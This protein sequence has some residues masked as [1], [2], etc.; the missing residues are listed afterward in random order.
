[1]TDRAIAF[2]LTLAAIALLVSL[3]AAGT[4]SADHGKPDGYDWANQ[5]D[6][7]SWFQDQYTRFDLI[8][9]YS[10]KGTP[11]PGD[12]EFEEMGEEADESGEMA[13]LHRMQDFDYNEPPQLARRWNY[14]QAVEKYTNHYNNAGSHGESIY[15]YYRDGDDFATLEGDD[16]YYDR[17]PY[18]AGKDLLGL[19][20]KTLLQKGHVSIFSIQ[21]S[22][23]VH[24]QPRQ[25]DSSQGYDERDLYIRK[26]GTVI[27]IGDA[28]ADELPDDYLDCGDHLIRRWKNDECEEGDRKYEWDV[29]GTGLKDVDVTITTPN[30][31]TVTVGS[32][33]EQYEDGVAVVSYQIPDDVTGEQRLEINANAYI[34]FQ[35][36]VYEQ[37]VAGTET[38]DCEADLK[39]LWDAGECLDDGTREV[40]IYEWDYSH[41]ETL[42]PDTVSVSDSQTVYIP[43]GFDDENSDNPTAQVAH[44]PHGGT[45]VKVDIS[46]KVQR[47]DKWSRLELQT[48]DP[49]RVSA[50]VPA[51][52]GETDINLNLERPVTEDTEV[53]VWARGDFGTLTKQLEITDQDG[54]VIFEGSSGE[55]D[56]RMS[57][58]HYLGARDLDELLDPTE[59]EGPQEVTLTA[60][61][62]EAVDEVNG[63]PPRVWLTVK[64]PPRELDVGVKSKWYY[65]GARHTG[66]DAMWAKVV[67]RGWYDFRSETR[68]E[69]SPIRPVWIHSYPKKNGFKSSV[70]VRERDY[71]T[72]AGSI[73]PETTTSPALDLDTWCKHDYWD[74]RKDWTDYAKWTSPVAFAAVE[75]YDYLY[76]YDYHEDQCFWNFPVANQ[77]DTDRKEYYTVEGVEYETLKSADSV[78]LHGMVQGQTVEAE[79]QQERTVELVDVEIETNLIDNEREEVAPGIYRVPAT[80]T[81]TNPHGEPISTEER[82]IAGEYIRVNN[83]RMGEDLHGNRAFYS[84]DFQTDEDG[85]VYTDVYISDDMDLEAEYN[86][87]QWWRIPED[88]QAYTDEVALQPAATADSRSLATGFWHLGVILIIPLVLFYYINKSVGIDFGIEEYRDLL[89]EVVPPGFWPVLFLG[90]LFLLVTY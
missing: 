81:V 11:D 69:E 54:N 12:E 73:N 46:D 80:I 27:A 71:K 77:T 75:I 16:E 49:T 82:D 90:L 26:Q 43:R 15:P 25:G 57:D 84:E 63:V 17:N 67:D 56:S 7:P 70:H 23:M 31:Q 83:S 58:K 14:H 24:E 85:K 36:R 2:A 5:T 45:Y 65:F 30:D 34:Q 79:I 13:M 50:E 21:P 4:A 42:D 8:K 62:S 9:L 41:T 51:N 28:R 22:T 68:R 47:D 37:T 55:S 64:H 33:T 61:T 89:V 88:Q 44:M 59:D 60:S 3:G 19:D 1:M 48:S 35:K 6:V 20:D 29:K 32:S 53:H 39:S 18:E 38:V 40:T 74:G 76:G 78:V 87:P 66:W 10:I 52:G 72:R 86:A